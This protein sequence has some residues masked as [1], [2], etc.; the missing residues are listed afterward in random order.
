MDTQQLQSFLHSNSFFLRKMSLIFYP[1]LIKL[2]TCYTSFFFIGIS[3]LLFF[4]W[5]KKPI[6]WTILFLNCSLATRPGIYTSSYGLQSH[7]NIHH[8]II[9]GTDTDGGIKSAVQLSLIDLTIYNCLV[10]LNTDFALMRMS[11]KAGNCISHNNWKRDGNRKDYGAN[12]LRGKFTMRRICATD[13]TTQ[14]H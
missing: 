14:I 4:S 3:L 6:I 5:L 10:G 9:T 1:F 8:Q 7:I 13:V 12:S 2:L 11:K